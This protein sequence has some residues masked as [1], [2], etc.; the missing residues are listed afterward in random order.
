MQNIS[1]HEVAKCVYDAIRKCATTLRPD[2]YAA[3]KSQLDAT[4]VCAGTGGINNSKSVLSSILENAHIAQADG[5]PICQDTG[6]VWVCLEVGPNVSVPGD[7]FSEVDC[8]V[9]RAYSDGRLRMSLVSDAL[10][11]RANTTNN[12]PAFCEVKFVDK[13]GVRVHVMLKGGGS[14]NASRV[15]MLPPGA[16]RAGVIDAVLACVKEKAANACPPL[17]VGVGVGA[18]FDKVAGMA[19]HALLREVGTPATNAQTAQFEAELLQKVNELSI[20]PG[21]L[22]GGPTALAVHVE[23]APCHIAA[24][25]VAINMGCC[26]MRTSTI[27]L[28]DTNSSDSQNAECVT[29]K[30]T[31]PGMNA[32][33]DATSE[34]PRITLPLTPEV[35]KTLKCGQEVLLTGNVFT[36]RDAGHKR[37]LDYLHEHGHLPFDLDGQILFYAGP[38]PEAAG[39]PLGSVGPTTASRMDFATPELLAAGIAGMI[40]KGK[41]SLAVREACVETGGVYFAA[42]GG[43]AALLAK[44]VKS[45]QLVGWEDLG[46]EALRKLYV[47]DFPVFVEIDT[48]G[49]DLYLQIENSN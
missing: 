36:M 6:S 15:V 17:I 41:R 22:G 45:S 8:A 16:G 13:P 24:L 14:D 19:K 4:G 38:T 40:G 46:T 39:R 31:Y 1:C 26:A 35:A 20:G 33:S 3:I 5:V 7:V 43:V 12:T 2:V 47:E 27:E 44:Q 18:T 37:C 29:S 23:T 10:F 25:P 34:K 42:V 30:T 49:N 48:Q 9:A 32:A 11:D 21:A 28:G